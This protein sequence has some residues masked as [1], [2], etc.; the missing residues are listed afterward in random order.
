MNR[1]SA[2]SEGNLEAQVHRPL[3]PW[4][5][6]SGVVSCYMCWPILTRWRRTLDKFSM[7]LFQYVVTILQPTPCFSLVQGIS[8]SLLEWIKVS[9]PTEIRYNS[10]T[11][12]G[13]REAWFHFLVQKEGTIQFSSYLVRYSKLLV[14]SNSITIY[15][16]WACR[17]KPMRLSVMSWDK[18][19][20]AL[21]IGS[22]HLPVTTWM[23]IAFTQQATSKVG[24]IEEPQ[25]AKFWRPALMASTILEELKKYT[26]FHFIV[27][28]L[29]ILSYLNIIGLILE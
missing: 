9:Y 24:P 18:L 26:N 14:R 10:F 22:G 6:K 16:A 27:A 21:P 13:T 7:N 19:Q 3:R 20:M 8:S 12:C 29:L 28:N 23:D 2:F 17:S 11:G 15:P 1:T 4:H 25:I 5:M